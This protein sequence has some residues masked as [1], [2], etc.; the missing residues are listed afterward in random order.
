MNSS[1]VFE[2]KKEIVLTSYEVKYVDRREK[3]P[4]KV[5]EDSIVMDNEQID[6]LNYLG[7]RDI[8]YIYNLY[9]VNG[10]IVK[11]VRNT[12]TIKAFVDLKSIWNRSRE[13]P[14]GDSFMEFLE[15]LGSMS[16]QDD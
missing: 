12:G 2:S 11:S 7:L 9:Q 16:N 15:K 1:M 4:R 8:G 10:Y 14:Q 13:Q 3:E 6:A 5:C